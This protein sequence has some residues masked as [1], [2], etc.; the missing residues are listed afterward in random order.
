MKNRCLYLL[1]LLL[2]GCTP[3]IEETDFGLYRTVRQK[4]SPELSYRPESGVT[5]LKV[6][7]HPFK[8]LNK[9][10][11]L[12]AYEDWRLPSEVRADSLVR[13]LSIEE[14]VGLMHYSAQQ[15]PTASELTDDMKAFLGPNH[16]RHILLAKIPDAR[17]GAEWSNN[18]Q[19][20][21]EATPLGIPANNSSDPRNYSKADGEFNA[22]SGGD[23]SHWP[24]EIGLAATFSTEV[25]RDFGEI[26][27]KEYRALGLT[28]TLSPQADIATEPRWRRFY[29]T[30]GEDPYL[31]RDLTQA[32]C[33]AFQTTPGSKTGWGQESVNCMVK[34]W[35]GGGTGEGGRDAHFSFGKYGVYPGG[36]FDLG[37]IPF[38]E[39][40]FKLKGKTRMASAVM[41]YY[42]I[43]YGQNPKGE[44][45]GNGFS[46]YIIQDLLRDKYHYQG[47]VCTDWG[48]VRGYAA[49]YVHSG[50]PWGVEDLTLAEKRLKALE[51]GVDQIGGVQDIEL[52]LEAYQLWSRKYGEESARS[53]FELSAKRLLVNFFN[54][55]V[56][57]NPYVN[58]DKA[59]KEVGCEK[60]M[61]AGYQAQLKSIVMTKNHAS[62]LPLKKTLKVYIP[63][64]KVGEGL[65]CWGTTTPSEDRC[66]FDSALVAR[67]YQQVEDPTEADFAIVFICSPV[68]S[69]GYH[70]P[71]LEG[72]IP[73]YREVKVKVSE[74]KEHFP[75]GKYAPISLQWND[76]I[77][78]EAREQSVAGGDPLEASNNRSYKGVSEHTTNIGDLTTVLETKRLMGSK[79]VVVVVAMDRPFIPAEI[80]PSADA[81]LIT[82]GASNQA[83]L[84]IVSGQFEPYGLLPCQLPRDMATVERQCEDVP[85]DMI[86]YQDADGNV[87]DF[88]FGMNWSGIINDKRV[89]RYAH[90]NYS[91]K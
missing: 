1:C 56:F 18:V 19:S 84:D 29:G 77:A 49:P 61:A 64:R 42:T 37:L 52:T 34:H 88:A 86:C 6:D 67:Y 40:A 48:I 46:R 11:R 25:V 33:D 65:T 54:V 41:P 78:V 59:A 2:A 80:E 76:Y 3:V 14:I 43:S 5:I 55:G 51:A 60:Y 69:W 32:F 20:F 68:G 87:Y 12:D 7:D 23:I 83:V 31:C 63:H 38:I 58:P 70:R 66:P 91:R 28:T 81:I 8:D 75:E 26:V 4:G 27:S 85:H 22:G 62:V 90:P 72:G 50:K 89:K 36:R 57:E 10:G 15:N 73:R 79:P 9:N 16:L 71:V 39:G 47:V 24:R 82:M 45:V 74:L 35:P 13:M 30:F 21:C 17:T 44:D 53:R